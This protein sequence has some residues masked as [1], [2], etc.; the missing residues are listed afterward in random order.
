VQD[1]AMKKS[2]GKVGYNSSE[3]YRKLLNW[4]GDP[5]LILEKQT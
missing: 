5:L 2:S 3:Q 1:V 4:I